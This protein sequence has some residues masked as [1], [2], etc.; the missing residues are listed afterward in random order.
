MTTATPH[1]TDNDKMA[2]KTQ[3]RRALINLR[4]KK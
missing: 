1:S 2:D 4:N 3:K